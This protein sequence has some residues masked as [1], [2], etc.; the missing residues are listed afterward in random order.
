MSPKRTFATSLR[1]LTQVVHD[2]RT[3]ALIL[4]V[5]G[6]L[7][8]ILR[9]V[10]DTDFFVFS[11]IAPILLGIIPFTMMF[12]VTSVAVLRERTSGTLE[13]LL[14]SPASKLDIIM[15]YAVSFAILA[16]AQAAV[17][18]FI[19]VGLLDVAIQSSPAILLLVAVLSG[20][21]GM[22]FGLFFSAFSK[23]EFQAVQFMPAFVLPQVLIGGLFVPRDSM[24]R[25]LELLSDILPLTYIIDAMKHITSVSGWTAEL[26]HN[27]LVISGFIVLALALGALSLRS[28]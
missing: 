15:G 28:K 16:A 2:H 18:S 21:L 17:A 26:T 3:M 7:M 19:T 9:Y 10:F 11:A 6:I 1:V 8:A 27:L 5:P 4:F 13:R 14:A 25:I 23:N 20:V 12:I 24:A 22:S